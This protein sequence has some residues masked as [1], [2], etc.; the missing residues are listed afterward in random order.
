MTAAQ[1]VRSLHVPFGVELRAQPR[2]VLLTC[3]FCQGK[4]KFTTTRNGHPADLPCRPCNSRG[5]ITGE[6]AIA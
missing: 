1:F 4:G 2:L 5:V 3:C 6:G